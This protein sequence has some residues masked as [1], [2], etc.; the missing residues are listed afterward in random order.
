MN[1]LARFVR[2]RQSSII[3]TLVLAGSMLGLAFL[4]AWVTRDMP[5]FSLLPPNGSVADVD[6]SQRQDLHR[7]FFTIWAALVLAAPGL[8]LIWLKDQSILAARFWLVFCSCFS[9]AISFKNR[10]SVRRP[11][12]LS[13]CRLK[14]IP[15]NS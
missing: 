8:G 4:A 5:L 11:L 12:S 15:S 1:L 10:C 6:P 13:V 9:A 7:T 2:S 14:N 3:T